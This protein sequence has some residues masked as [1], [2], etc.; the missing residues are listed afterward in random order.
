MASQGLCHFPETLREEGKHC[1]GWQRE[2]L[3]QQD[4]PEVTTGPEEK[5]LTR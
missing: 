1:P 5:A 2:L 3:P 4:L